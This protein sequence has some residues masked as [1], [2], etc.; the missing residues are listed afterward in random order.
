MTKTV[1]VKLKDPFPGHGG[2]MDEV[3]L[4]EPRGRDYIELGDPVSY[5]RADKGLIVHAENDAAIKSYI[6]RCIVSPDALLA[7]ANLTLV[8]MMSV[9]DAL[10]DFFADARVARLAKTSSSS[11]ST[12]DGSAPT[13]PAT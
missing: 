2:M 6:E 4:R 13:G 5:A 1:T 8:D 10:L 3:V 7:M 11:S 9:K 12:S